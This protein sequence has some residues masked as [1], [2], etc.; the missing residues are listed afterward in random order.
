MWAP[1][2][3]LLDGELGIEDGGSEGQGIREK[4][5]KKKKE[6]RLATLS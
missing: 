2:V 4:T 1:V 6:S 5:Q 3:I